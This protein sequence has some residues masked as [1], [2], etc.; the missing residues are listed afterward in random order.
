[1]RNDKIL[2]YKMRI[3]GQSYA[4]I[5]KG[6]GMSKSTLSGW[7]RHL[8]IPKE[9]HEKIINQSRAASINALL[10]VNRSKTMHAEDRIKTARSS[11]IKEIGKLS[12]RDLLLA[13]VTLYWT[14][15]HKRSIV[16]KDR[17]RTYHAV[18]ITTS[19]LLKARIFIRFLRELCKIPDEKITADLRISQQQQTA[20][21]VDIWS[22]ATGLP[23]SSFRKTYAT[24]LSLPNGTIQIRV[25]STPLFHKIMGWIEGLQN[26]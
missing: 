16:F 19:D 4:E 11:S 10:K 20:Y 13:G 18:S 26:S 1:M 21:V 2:A 22:K 12:R 25:N 15:G 8:V 5:S 17:V 23:L 14:E 7:F 3:R 9:A 6:L 24:K